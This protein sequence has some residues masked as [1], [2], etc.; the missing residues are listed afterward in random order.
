MKIPLLVVIVV[1]SLVLSG[2]VAAQEGYVLKAGEGEPLLTGTVV[3][4]SPATGT[5][6]AI[7]VEQTFDRGGDTGLHLHEQGDELFYV[8]SGTGVATLGENEEPVGPGDV[9]FV[10]RGATHMIGNPDSPSPLV[11]VFFMES[12]ELVEQFRAIHE[13]RT[14]NPDEPI[15]PEERAEIESKIGGAIRIQ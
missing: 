2:A 15:S 4:A 13:R 10:P 9:I 7:L 14:Q 3:K 1:A 11:V 6:N 5:E 12:A 8:V